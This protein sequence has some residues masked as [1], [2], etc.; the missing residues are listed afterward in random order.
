M[1][2]NYWNGRHVVVT[3]ASGFIGSHVT[4][5]L[6]AKGAK[7]TATT[8]L[9]HPRANS[10]NLQSVS[11]KVAIVPSELT[12]LENCLQVCHN[13]EVVINAAHVDGS[14][15]F[16]RARPAHIFRRNMLITLN[17]LEAALRSKVDRFLVMSSTEVY[18]PDAPIPTRESE[19]LSGLPARLTDGYTWSKRMSELAAEF[20]AREYGLKV[21]IA[22]PGSTYGPRDDFDERRGRVI[23]MLIKKV[24]GG[25]ESVTIWGT[26]EQ[27]RSFLY[28]ED[29]ARGLLDLVEKHPQCDP[30]N[31]SSDEQITIRGLA[32]LIVRLSGRSVRILCDPD[33][34]SGP[35]D[36]TADNT[37]AKQILDFRETTPLE[38]GLRRTI[39]MYRKHT[40]GEAP[41]GLPVTR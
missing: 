15:A 3:G 27:R 36:R 18:A 9:V 13:Q 5:L 29:L 6:V 19:G 4:E 30:I 7:V 16:K 32:E 33:K 21:A 20:F 2:S 40:V 31:F 10:L 34:P 8:P 12:R 26:G 11:E 22:R 41:S 1:T 23:P 38:T 28:V 17:M 14:V 37:K 24:C 39:D 35:M 25:D